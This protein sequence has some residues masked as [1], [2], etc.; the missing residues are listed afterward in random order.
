MGLRIIHLLLCAK[1]VRTKESYN[2]TSSKQFLSL[3]D[4]TLIHDVFSKTFGKS[5]SKD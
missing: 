1:F 3:S 2:N 5:F 4:I